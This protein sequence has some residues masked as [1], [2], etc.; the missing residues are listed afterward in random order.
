MNSVLGKCLPRPNSTKQNIVK[1]VLLRNK[2]NFLSH[3]IHQEYLI[4]T[5]CQHF[6]EK[7][8]KC[9]HAAMENR[10]VKQE[11]AGMRLE[12]EKETKKKSREEE[13]N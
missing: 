4:K 12:V 5:F 10:V 7:T 11:S 6:C 9:A 8:L 1:A 13:M 2:R 3:R